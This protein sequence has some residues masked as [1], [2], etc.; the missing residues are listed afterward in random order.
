MKNVALSCILGSTI[1]I[2]LSLTLWAA[3]RPSKT[4]A[5]Y[6]P[7]AIVERLEPEISQRLQNPTVYELS[8]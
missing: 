4:A 7:P 2:M 6:A 5:C 1:M 3:Y 8:I